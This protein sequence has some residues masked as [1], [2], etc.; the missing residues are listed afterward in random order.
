[1]SSIIKRQNVDVEARGGPRRNVPAR[2]DTCTAKHV[3]SIEVGGVVRAIE[4]V[5]SCGERSVIEL[6]FER[7]P[8]SAPRAG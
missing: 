3:R 2:P 5:C 8:N 1:M 4:F 6:E 7:N